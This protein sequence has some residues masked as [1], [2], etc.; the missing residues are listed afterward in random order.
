MVAG[1]LTA[2]ADS[3]STPNGAYVYGQDAFPTS[4]YL[5]TNYWVDVVFVDS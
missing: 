1:P 4:S 3:G 5:A 2:S